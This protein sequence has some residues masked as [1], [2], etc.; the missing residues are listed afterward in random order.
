MDIVR[1]AAQALGQKTLQLFAMNSP[2]L[3]SFSEARP[4]LCRLGIHFV[5]R[6]RCVYLISNLFESLVFLT[7]LTVMHSPMMYDISFWVYSW[8]SMCL[9][10]TL[11]L[12]PYISRGELKEQQAQQRCGGASR[13]ARETELQRQH[14]ARD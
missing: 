8:C 10:L 7:I 9:Q 6:A 13:W 14:E 12:V 4:S 3:F 5:Y 2:C 1:S 11:V